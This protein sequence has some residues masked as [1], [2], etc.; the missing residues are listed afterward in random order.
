MKITKA[1]SVPSTPVEVE[2][3]EG[4]SIRLL[5]HEAD[6]APNFYMRMFTIAP[7]GHTPYHD[8]EWEHEVYIL[9][10]SGEV[11]TPDGARPIS[12]GFVVYVAPG[13]THNFVNTG[14]GEI[15]MLCLVPK[16]AKG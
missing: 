12:P 6:Q 1:E 15:K 7:G 4:I 3:A 2:G 5:I 13:E 16:T 8:H 14:E 11:T 9:A 10:G